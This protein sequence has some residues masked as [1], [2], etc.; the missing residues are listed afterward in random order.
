MQV[1]LF[2]LTS[3]E[4]NNVV[5]IPHNTIINKWFYVNMISA[6]RVLSCPTNL[7]T[8]KNKIKIKTQMKRTN[9]NHTPIPHNNQ[10]TFS[11]QYQK[12]ILIQHQCQYFTFTL[13]LNILLLLFKKDCRI[14]VCFEQ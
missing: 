9:N 3:L 11:Q 12:P 8:H 1:T 7:S 10:N 13:D 4:N 14:N 2:Y 5:M 6:I